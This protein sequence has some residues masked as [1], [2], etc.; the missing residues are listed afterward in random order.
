MKQMFA[1]L[2][3]LGVFV[4]SP[5]ADY[6]VTMQQTDERAP[7]MLMQMQVFMSEDNLKMMNPGETTTVIYKSKDDAV[8]MVDDSKRQFIVMNEETMAQMGSQMD[9]MMKQMEE[10]L[11]ELP[12]EQ[13]EMAE[14]MMKEKM[15]GTQ[16]T[17][18]APKVE[19]K[20]AGEKKD[21]DGKPCERYDITKDG[22]KT[23]EI[24]VT[25]WS[26]VGMSE[27]DFAIF[28][29]MASFMQNMMSSS[30]FFKNS[31]SDNEFF[32]GIEQIDGFPVM[33]REFVDGEVT[34]ETV[35]K[36]VVEKDLD[37]STFEISSDYERF[38]PMSEMKRGQ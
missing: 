25:S 6:I 18:T 37:P 24:W 16:P 30:D 33:T 3:I 20:K 31:V 29:E 17:M 34:E 10:A 7:E 21:I 23:T 4:G 5:L 14:K 13:R 2:L 8:Y 28:R 1:V 26:E 35:L 36:S 19:V 9:A 32:A 38:D 12:P 11:A 22:K 27:E 15:P